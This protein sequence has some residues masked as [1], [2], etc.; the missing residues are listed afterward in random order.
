MLALGRRRRGKRGVKQGRGRGATRGFSPLEPKT[1]GVE[2]ESHS[3]RG[4]TAPLPLRR[5]PRGR[6]GSRMDAVCAT[7]RAGVIETL[8]SWTYAI[9]A[10]LALTAAG[11]LYVWLRW[12]RSPHA[13]R[14]MIGVAVGYFIAGALASAWAVHLT[15]PTPAAVVAAS[16]G[17]VA[18][19]QPDYLPQ[20]YAGKVVGVT[21]GDT[22]DVAIAPEGLVH[23]IRLEGIDAPESA[24]AFG[25]DSTRHLSGL[26]SGKSVAL[27]CEYERSYGRLICTVLLPDGEDV[28]LDQVKAGMAWHYKQYQDEQSPADRETYGAAECAAMKGKV[29]L[30]S[31]AHPTQPQDFRHAT[32]SPLLYDA[33]GCRRSSEPTNGAVIGNGH[34]HIFEWPGCPYYDS[35][36]IDNQ[37]PFPSPQAAAAAGYRPAH[38]CP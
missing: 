23:S 24:Q 38:N 35:I 12:R 28:C 9:G 16:P 10:A 14:A 19:V 2:G 6:S 27:K 26:V 13:Y 15:S 33:A 31:D 11:A 18:S 22:I 4:G 8:M 20:R 36:S 34:T 29:G 30:W 1:S 7:P 5:R 32:H 3:N 37:V 25:A 21:D 17:S